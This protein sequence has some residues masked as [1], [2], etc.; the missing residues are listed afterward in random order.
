MKI[1][2]NTILAA[3]LFMVTICGIATWSQQP[4]PRKFI[5]CKSIYALCTFSK[6]TGSHASVMGATVTCG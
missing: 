2:R 5:V 3:A 6:C 4:A 1:N